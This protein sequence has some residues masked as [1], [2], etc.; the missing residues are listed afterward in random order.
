MSAHDPGSIDSLRFAQ[1]ASVREGDY[2]I[3]AMQRVMEM[4]PNSTG[5]EQAV[6]S[7]RLQGDVVTGRAQLHLQ[8]SGNLELQCQRCLQPMTYPLQVD[9]R[10]W[11]ARNEAEL[12]RWDAQAG[13][14][15]HGLEEAVAADPHLDVL[16]FVED[17]I[18]LSLPVAPHH[19]DGKCPDMGAAP[20][21]T[22]F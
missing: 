4:M 10:V 15:E 9:S 17:E 16:L 2:A 19:P 3:A 11:L 21:V 14:S 22:G 5:F 20:D 1:T 12:E 6:V 13:D 7:Y 18:L 8:V